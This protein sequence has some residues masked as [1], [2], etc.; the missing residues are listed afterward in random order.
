[1]A[2]GVATL[3]G[4]LRLQR[5]TERQGGMPLID[6][7]LLQDREGQILQEY[8]LPAS[9][10]DQALNDVLDLPDVARPGI[11]AKRVHCHF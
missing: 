1:M 3:F 9:G 10:H 7:A 5:A 4:F 8:D 11:V 2:A 6:L